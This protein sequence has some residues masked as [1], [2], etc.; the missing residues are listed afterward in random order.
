M[1]RSFIK[2]PIETL[3]ELLGSFPSFE[4]VA[5][6]DNYVEI[7]Q[8]FYSKK[9][10][11]RIRRILTVINDG[12]YNSEL[13]G[14]E[15]KSSKDPRITAMKFKD[16]ANTRIYCREFSLSSGR[17]VVML[18]AVSKKSQ[19]NDKRILARLRAYGEYEYEFNEF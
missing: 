5:D 19:K 17:K 6:S 10:L 14:K 1:K 11:S 3:L 8:I 9:N 13:Y 12:R 18:E 2:I 15:W 4:L 7:E 16:S